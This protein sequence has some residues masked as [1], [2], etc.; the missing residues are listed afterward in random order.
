MGP[1]EG[2]EAARA[3][4]ENEAMRFIQELARPV[5]GLSLSELIPHFALP[6][7]R[8]LS[9][10]RER[11]SLPAPAQQTVSQITRAMVCPG[12]ELLIGGEFQWPRSEHAQQELLQEIGA[13][14]RDVGRS[15]KRTTATD[16]GRGET[17]PGEE[18]TAPGC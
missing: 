11:K 10:L 6:V 9:M 18:S 14:L 12:L 17:D 7:E 5:G 4:A 13:T 16:A 15:Q 1:W 3:P 8:N 2:G